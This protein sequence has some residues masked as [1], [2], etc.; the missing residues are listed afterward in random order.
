[1]N[2]SRNYAKFCRLVLLYLHFACAE[3]A[4]RRINVAGHWKALRAHKLLPTYDSCG[5]GRL[6]TEWIDRP[7][8]VCKKGRTTAH[9]SRWR[10]AKKMLFF[11]KRKIREIASTQKIQ[12][13]CPITTKIVSSFFRPKLEDKHLRQDIIA[14][15]SSL[16]MLWQIFRN[17]R[18]LSN[19]MPKCSSSQKLRE[20]PPCCMFSCTCGYM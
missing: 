17:N 2:S 1:M 6:F 12:K 10:H 19:G 15:G 13:L 3:A 11:A 9:A 16:C 8:T 14:T 18:A 7:K 5:V 4:R 20:S